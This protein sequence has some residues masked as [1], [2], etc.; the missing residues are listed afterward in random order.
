[1]PPEFVSRKG[2]I[3]F[4]GPRP[5]LPNPPEEPVQLFHLPT[6]IPNPRSLKG[7]SVLLEG[8]LRVV[9]PFGL[10]FNRHFLSSNK[11]D[12]KTN[13]LAVG[14]NRKEGPVYKYLVAIGN[15]PA[16]Q[17]TVQSQPATGEAG[18]PVAPEGSQAVQSEVK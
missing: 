6:V 17:T 13:L 4:N 16:D 14:F 1:M 15:L 9:Q 18:Q 3:D 7:R 5:S 8:S 10:W 11:P 12:T 2:S